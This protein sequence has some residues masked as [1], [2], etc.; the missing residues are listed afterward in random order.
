LLTSLLAAVLL[1]PTASAQ[2]LPEGE[3]IYTTQR[4]Q[5]YEVYADGSLNIGG[6]VLGSCDTVLQSVRQGPL[7]PTRETYMQIEACEEAGFQVPGSES[8]PETGGPPV[9]AALAVLLAGGA[10]LSLGVR[11]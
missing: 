6:D 5:G 9:L 1:A 2:G 8:L 3:P 4:G 11:R 7:E 10:I